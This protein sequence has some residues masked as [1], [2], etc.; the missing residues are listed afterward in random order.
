MYLCMYVCMYV[1]Y[2]L[3]VCVST[4]MSSPKVKRMP[5]E[6][7]SGSLWCLF[8]REAPRVA[9]CEYTR[10]K[11]YACTMFIWNFV[12]SV[13]SRRAARRAGRFHRT[14]NVRMYINRFL[15]CV[16]SVCERAAR[17]AS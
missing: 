14:P 3:H 9:R 8:F 12:L 4:Y 16:V 10:S 15:I 13:F 6:C 2:V 7:S 11:A 17:R 5:I 1:F